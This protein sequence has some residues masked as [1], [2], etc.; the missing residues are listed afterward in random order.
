MADRSKPSAFARSHGALWYRSLGYRLAW[1]ALPQ[2]LV[3]LVIG[4]FFMGGGIG[5]LSFGTS[6][7]PAEKTAS[8]WAKP[9]DTVATEE[10]L[11]VLREAAGA[12]DQAALDGLTRVAEGGD[13]IASFKLG[14]LYAPFYAQYYPF[15]APKD[16]TRAIALFEPAAKAGF[17]KAYAGLGDIYLTEPEPLH[18][19][20][21]GCKNLIAY[22][23]TPEWKATSATADDV[24]EMVNGANCLLN[25]L[26]VDGAAFV[27]P[28]REAAEK[29]LALL[30]DP[31]LAEDTLALWSRVRLLTRP[32]SPVF[33]N[34]RACAAAEA[35]VKRTTPETRKPGDLYILTKLA[36]CDLGQYDTPP[37][38]APP[39]AKQLEALAL[40]SLPEVKSDPFTQSNLAWLLLRQGDVFDPVAGCHT[41]ENWAALVGTDP[42][43]IGLLNPVT[44]VQFADCLQGLFPGQA[45]RTP[46]SQDMKLVF[47]LGQTAIDRGVPEG[48]YLI[49]QIYRFG[50]GGQPVNGPKAVQHFEAC[51]VKLPACDS[52][53]GDI[54][55][56][57]VAG[58]AKDNPR[59]VKHF[60]LC[61]AAGVTN[62][63]AQ[64]SNIYVNDDSFDVSGE[65]VLGHMR[66]AAEAGESLA[67]E[68][69]AYAY[70]QGRFGLQ[71]DMDAAAGWLVRAIVMPGGDGVRDWLANN[72]DQLKKGEF[73]SSMHRELTRRGVYAG[74]ADTKASPETIAA[75]YKLK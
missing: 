63:D 57:G 46:S 55:A 27:E 26:R 4:M 2:A 67:A 24:S 35:W 48:D 32:T 23:D 8:D 43:E 1:L 49:G 33:D 22:L 56:Y 39:K 10:A 34:K 17:W 40:L 12:G 71:V 74:K 3:A 60:K 59:A 73:W 36:M 31:V 64:L 61:A 62:C 18:D 29:A 70:Y 72:A 65:E 19:A 14:T 42:V 69:L 53:L 16:P 20:E 38:A 13:A 11:N 15:P 37:S 58:F 45:A 47:A 21:K 52:S 30:E 75:L 9:M 28:S 44:A 51:S 66:K 68:N 7:P 50:G 54:F 5:D 6:K 41:V 25:E